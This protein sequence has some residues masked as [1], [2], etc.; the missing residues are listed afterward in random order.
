MSKK[1]FLHIGLQKTG[2]SSIQVMLASSAKHLEHSGYSYPMLPVPES[3]RSP[4]WT[5]PFRHNCVAATYADF[6]STFE[7]L[8]DSEHNA[9]VS[10]MLDSKLDSIM[11]AEE[12]SR[13][14]DF[15]ALANRLREFEITVILYLRRQDRYIESLYNQRNKIL[16]SRCD[17]SFL[18]V[19]FLSH[20]DMMTFIRISGYD[21]IMEFH[22]LLLK[23]NTQLFPK[24]IYVRNF[25]RK[26]LVREDVCQDFCSL[27]D[28]ESKSMVHPDVEANQSIGNAVLSSINKAFLADGEDAARHMMTEINRMMVSGQDFSG[29]Y[30]VLNDKERDLVLDQYSDQ[31]E[32]LR[33]EFNINFN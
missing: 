26:S 6:H 14:K 7:P 4:V 12:F 29:D 3:K 9:L 22:T 17:T 30:R 1:L 19:D 24:K 16:V 13:Q 10:E 27:L 21:K 18:G 33:R 25:D 20:K 8:T 32:K 5:S 2:T 11:S 31:N 23:I 28:I 15:S